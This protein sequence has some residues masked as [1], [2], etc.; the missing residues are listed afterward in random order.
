M[1]VIQDIKQTGCPSTNEWVKKM[2]CM[3]H[4]V[5]SYSAVKS[6]ILS[7]E[8]TSVDLEG[9]MPC[10]NKSEKDKRDTECYHL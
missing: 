8:T 2:W 10:G 7:L 9:I 1:T 4:M 6:E 3:Q 5:K